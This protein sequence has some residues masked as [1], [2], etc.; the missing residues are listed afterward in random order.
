MNYE[1]VVVG[2]GIGGLTTAALMAARGVSVC[3]LERNSYVG[4]C[5][6][7]VAHLGYEFEPTYALYQGFGPGEVF[8]QV[9]S[10]LRITAPVVK[11]LSPA[12]V[13][14]LPDGEEIAITSE[15]DEF[16]QSLRQAF[17]ECSDAAIGFYRSLT[18]SSEASAG[19]P[20]STYLRNGSTRFRDFV[21]AQLQTF[22]QRSSDTCSLEQA[23]NILNSRRGFWSIDGGAQSLAETLAESISKSGG[24]IRL[25]APVLRFAYGFD[26]QPAGVDLLT[27]QQVLATKAIVSDLTVWDTYGKLIGLRRAP[28]GAVSVLRSLRSFGAYLL[29][30]SMDAAAAARLPS[31]RILA[32]TKSQQTERHDPF[33]DQLF[34]S[35]GSERDIAPPGKLPV[36]VT[37]FTHAE[38]WFSFHE[39]HGAHEEQ[40][41]RMLETVWSR[42]HSSMPELGDAVEVIESASPQTFYETTRRKF[43]MVGPADYPS[44]QPEQVFTRPFPNVFIV[45]D[46]AQG[47]FGIASVAAMA[48]NVSDLLTD[49][50]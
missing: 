8:D 50:G 32:L 40:D 3:V 22:L 35:C 38:D 5:A 1:L 4:G 11:Q 10:E 13:V 17:P 43:G 42:L 15:V 49:W 47:R 37:T 30:L 23:A 18:T 14:R 31:R 7:N 24:T 26:G 20:V 21:D 6:A 41:Q 25:N 34:F 9:F 16:E 46:T 28:S 36:T 29:F 39:D 19:S 44:G 12:Y 33:S 45:S 2:G 27:G 48:V